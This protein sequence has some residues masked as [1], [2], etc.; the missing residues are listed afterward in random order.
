MTALALLSLLVWAYLLGCRGFFWQSG[1]VLE[2]AEPSVSPTVAVVVPARNEAGVIAQSVKSLL[3]QNYKGKLTVIVVD[4]NSGDGTGNLARAIDDTRLTVVSG[5]SRPTGWSGKLW[6][7]RQGVAVAADAE[8]ILLTD[9]DIVH[10]VAHLSTLVAQMEA[11]QLDLVSE[12]V[13]LSCDS[14]AERALVPAFVFFFQMLYPFAWVNDGLNPV[15]AAAGGTILLRNRALKRIGGI[16]CL[17]GAL[18]DDVALASAIKQGGRIWLGHASMARSIR[19][20]PGITDIWNMITRT[21]FVQLRFSWLILV[22]TTLAM[23]VIWLLPPILTLTQH[24]VARL[25]GAIAWIMLTISYIPTLRRFD[26]SFLW[27]VALPI[28]ALFYMAATIAS[29]I[30]HYTGRGVAWKGRAY[31]GNAG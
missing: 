31:S 15:A 19:P 14:L 24:G 5:A 1:P 9:A 7:V 11:R 16:E 23:M 22:A 29:A 17:K 28:I 20:Y 6:A 10:E 2:P 30:N 4:D 8:L 25:Y 26:R 13:T 3:A 12:M 18:I 21:A 27:V